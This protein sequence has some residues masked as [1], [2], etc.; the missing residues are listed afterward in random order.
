MTANSNPEKRSPQEEQGPHRRDFC[1]T[2]LTGVLAG[3]AVLSSTEASTGG[4]P[5][6]GQKRMSSIKLAVQMD[7]FSEDSTRPTREELL[8][9]QQLGVQYVAIWVKK[10]KATAE[11]F[12]QTVQKYKAAGID[13][14]NIGNTDVHN[15][16]EV[17]L[18]LPGRDRKIEEYIEYLHNLHE[19][20]LHYTTYAHMG[21]GIWSTGRELIRGAS[22]RVF[23]LSQ[24]KDGWWVGKRFQGPLTHG[25]AYTEEEIW[26]NFS[27]FIKKVAPVAEKLDI[28][29]GIHPD[30]PPAPELGGIP[31]C[32]FSSFEGY[33]RALE[34]AGSD[35]VGI[36]LCCG[37]WL[38]GG[39]L[40]GKDVLE[41]IRYF[42]QR[43]KIFKVHF[44]NVSTPLPRFT[45]TF[46]DNGYMDM[47]LIMKALVEIGFD[48][49]VIPDHIPK[50]AGAPHA[51]IAYSIGYMRAL[52]D[53]AEREST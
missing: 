17:T 11:T 51:G 8:F 20:E 53:R 52:L 38:E 24:A 2:L 35:H 44:R 45:E 12:R 40:M 4:E 50:M 47:Y 49:A 31:R 41:T 39:P 21:N 23:D 37:C 14:W 25:R 28:R 18:H 36:C 7:H 10:N 34:I 48:G 1:K 5:P 6:A 13:V 46:L 32:I 22:A 3:P 16:E 43:K 15:M 26:E 33:R 9:L 42:G 27:Y 19:A 30:D 29:I